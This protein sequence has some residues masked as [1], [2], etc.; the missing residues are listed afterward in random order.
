[1][2]GVYAAVM[3]RLEVSCE[4]SI[5]APP[6][7][8]RA[9]FGDVAHHA[10]VGVHRGVVFVVLEETAHVC[11]Y[12]QTTSLGPLRLRQELA[13]ARAPTGPLVNT[14]VR[15]QFSGG[16]ITFDV[17]PDTD[18]QSH[19]TASL[20]ADLGALSL[21]RPLLRRTVISSLSAALAEDKHDLESG[22]YVVGPT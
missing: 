5:D 22:T 11:R 21:L 3:S 16:S 4:I 10:D 14:I 15:G 1:M 8:V 7:A 19:V 18:E 2:E 9:Q 17:Q 6:E 20:S 12:R 13:L